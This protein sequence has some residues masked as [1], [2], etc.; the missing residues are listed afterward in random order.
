MKKYVDVIYNRLLPI[1][2]ILG[3]GTG[4]KSLKDMLYRFRLTSTQERTPHRG[5]VNTSRSHVYPSAEHVVEHTL[6]SCPLLRMPYAPCISREKCL[7]VL[8][9]YI[10]PYCLATI[11]LAHGVRWLIRTSR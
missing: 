6:V 11:K 5:G 2:L 9:N 4:N 10:L 3:Y 8:K 7:P 1:H